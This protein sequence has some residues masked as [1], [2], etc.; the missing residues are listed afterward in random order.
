MTAEVSNGL[1]CPKCGGKLTQYT[2]TESY[3]GYKISKH[4]LK[5]K[6]CNYREV[7]QEVKIMKS[8]NAVTIQIPRPVYQQIR[9]LKIKSKT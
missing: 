5:C 8:E 6:L 7:T 1:K 9:N 4:I 3:N 2:E